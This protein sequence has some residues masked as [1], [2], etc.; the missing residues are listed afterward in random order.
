MQLAQSL[1]LDI[2]PEAGDA[3]MT[4]ADVGQKLHARGLGR[5]W[6]KTVRRSLERLEQEG[7]AY[8]E[9]QGR[10]LVW[11]RRAGFGG[12]GASAY[13][14]MQ[15]SEA[16]AL[17]M[18]DVAARAYQLPW[19]VRSELSPMM[20]AA[21]LR[22]E[23]TPIGDAHKSWESRIAV[24]DEGFTRLPA[25]VDTSVAEI[26]SMALFKTLRLTIRYL[27]KADAAQDDRSLRMA[28]VEPLAWV[29]RNQLH[30]LVARKT[31]TGQIRHYRID[32]IQAAETGRSF[33]YPGDFSLQRHIGD[34]AF[35]YAR[36]DKIIVVLKFDRAHGLH[37]LETPV[38]DTQ[39]VLEETTAS[40]TF[41][42][43]VWDSARLS[44][45]IR[46]FG[47]YVEVLEPGSL[48]AQ[49]LLEARQ[50]LRRYAADP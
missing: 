4:T 17:R 36:R 41:R 1:L 22:L 50:L 47:P 37:L 9:R 10:H 48:R 39:T 15:L 49:M 30:Y 31:D 19:V 5:T 27:N 3:G 35:D 25:A 18:L 43:E 40:L 8:S 7:L 20:N 2:L 14:R 13:K 24:L 33:A 38:N 32:R 44:W 11:W 26:L 16:L 12:I 34:G 23:K 6:L 21:R 45:W 29:A 46:G 28:E 42:F